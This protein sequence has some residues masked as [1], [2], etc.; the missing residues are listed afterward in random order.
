MNEATLYGGHPSLSFGEGPPLV[1]LPGLTATH[2]VPQGLDRRAQLGMLRRLA[3]RYTVHWVNRRPGLDVGTTMADLAKQYAEALEH[4]FEPPVS[5]MGVSTGGSTALQLAVDHPHL[6]SRMAV[7]CGACRLS[8]EGRAIQAEF[9]RLIA[10][11][12]GRQAWAM[13]GSAMAVGPITRSAIRAAMWA[14]GSEMTPDDP[15]DLVRTVQAEDGFD[16]TTDLH[17]ITAPTLVVGGERDVLYPPELLKITADGIRSSTL[18]VIKGAGH[19]RGSQKGVASP[20][21]SAFLGVAK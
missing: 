5:L 2:T 20:V 19:M 3:E 9:A 21:L 18:E 17:R 10:A 13:L 8:D 1:V 6:V 11:G 4:S 15:S 7:V 12:K 16:T 14:L